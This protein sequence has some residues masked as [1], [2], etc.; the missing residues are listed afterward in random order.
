MLILAVVLI[1]VVLGAT[2][3]SFILPLSILTT[4]PLSAVGAFWFIYLTGTPFDI[5][6]MIGFILLAGIVVKNGIM[7]VDFIKN[8]R[9][10]GTDR[11]TAI[12]RSGRDR[13][14]PVLMTALTTILGCVPLVVGSSFAREV[15]FE[16]VG[17]IVIGGL[18]TGTLLTLVIVPVVYTVIDDIGVWASSYFATLGRLL[19]LGRSTA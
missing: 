4:L 12:L 1:Y 9:D 18:I 6:C 7:L 16:G 15:S 13:L 11:Y 3:E 19:R 14:R 8:E 2:F 5:L 17:K 10:A